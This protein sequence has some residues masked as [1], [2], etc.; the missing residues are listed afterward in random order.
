MLVSI[1]VNNYNYADYLEKCIESVLHQTY[2]DIEVIVYDDGSTDHSL[3][4]LSKFSNI[5][6]IANENYGKNP[7]I[8]QINAVYQA[9]LHCKG[10]YIFLLDSDDWF[11]EDKVEKVVEAFLENPQVEAIQHY[12]V[13][14]DKSGQSLGSVVPVIK[15]VR[16]YRSYIL[17]TESL[18]H[19]FSTTSALAFKRSFL[20][21]VMPLQEDNIAYLPIDTRLMVLASMTTHIFTIFEPLSFYRKHG[22]NVSNRL[23]DVSA[24][25][26]YCY[27]LYDFFNENAIENNFPAINYTYTKFL[28]NT[29]FFNHIGSK[30]CDNFIGDEP[31]W[32]WGA[33]EAGQSIFHA[34]SK[35]SASCIGFIDSDPKKQGATIMGLKV[36]APDEVQYNEHIRIIIS[37]YHAYDVI[38]NGLQLDGLGEGL[39]FIDPYLR[40][41]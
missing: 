20:E 5:K 41:N 33:G 14:V 4:V 3:D 12:L 40:E 18:F 21:R 23:G 34:L 26:Q 16:N 13:E 37:P 15:E 29:F 22:T 39:Q 35:K 7:S 8:N 17:E 30:K 27:D 24:H 28:E 38:K 25:Q 32:I 9:F 6:V 36:L 19:L 31:Y 10:E 1:L 11:R 2:E